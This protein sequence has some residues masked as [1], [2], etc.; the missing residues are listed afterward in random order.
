MG[1]ERPDSNARD[2][3]TTPTPTPIF[4]PEH[5]RCARHAHIPPG[6]PVPNCRDC[7]DIRQQAR[8]MAAD[9]AAAVD[10]A[11][12][13]HR[14]RVEACEVCDENGMRP[15]SLGLARCTHPELEP[16]T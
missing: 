10:E 15:T 6:Q 7:G 14:A 16:A 13:D 3:Q 4:D 2:F 8:A 11:K 9:E 12:A 5:P 1:G